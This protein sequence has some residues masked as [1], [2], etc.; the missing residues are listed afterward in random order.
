MTEYIQTKY[1]EVSKYKIREAHQF[2]TDNRFQLISCIGGKGYLT[3]K[4]Q[5]FDIK[6]GDQFLIP[7]NMD[8]FELRGMIDVIITK[9]G[10][11]KKLR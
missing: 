6:T 11:R 8:E 4:G 7:A 2:T 3:Y 1:F 5:I 10:E 9:P